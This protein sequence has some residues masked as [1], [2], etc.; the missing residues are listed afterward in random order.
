MPAS[1]I[2]EDGK[3]EENKSSQ[4][5]RLHDAWIDSDFPDGITDHAPVFMDMLLK[6]A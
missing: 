5:L 2:D 3:K 4:Q 1:M 6:Q